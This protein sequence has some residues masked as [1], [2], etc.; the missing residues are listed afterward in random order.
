MLNLNFQLPAFPHY[1][2]AFSGGADSTALLAAL[3]E[4]IGSEKLSA[5]H[6]DHQI[7]GEESQRDARWCENFCKEKGVEFFLGSADVTAQGGNLEAAART[8][9]YLWFYE[10][11]KKQKIACLLTAH[12]ATDAAETFLMH[13]A[14]GAGFAGL[15]GLREKEDFRE[16]F[17]VD[18]NFSLTVFRPLL[19]YSG[20]VLK[21]YC[22]EREINFREDQT[23]LDLSYDRNWL[24]QEILPR[25][26]A[27]YGGAVEQRLRQASAILSDG[28]DFLKSETLK[29]LQTSAKLTPFGAAINKAAFLK[30]PRA[31]Q[32]EGLRFLLGGGDALTFAHYESLLDALISDKKPALPL[33]N[34]LAL[35]ASGKTFFFLALG[36]FNAAAFFQ[37]R[38]AFKEVS[39]RS[40]G[41]SDGGEGV[42]AWLEK[43]EK[44]ILRQYLKKGSVEIRNYQEGL[45]LNLVNGPSKKLSDLYGGA[46]FPEFLRKDWPLIFIDGALSWIPGFRVCAE[47]AVKEGELCLEATLELPAFFN[48][49]L[50]SFKKFQRGLLW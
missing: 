10:V 2:V 34:G 5:L 39:L 28:L 44:I 19:N 45:K 32:R 35:L 47:G 48:F 8:A 17:N 37:S 40:R 6:F 46:F 21:E 50:P 20:E 15:A 30:A 24:R 1:A 26:N 38:L 31:L 18:D 33:P 29:F 4:T 14:R 16:L 11:C 13:L 22:K 41:N 49:D 12:H 25:L 43:G 27:R 36:N 3:C 9:R 23:N 42:L 7:R